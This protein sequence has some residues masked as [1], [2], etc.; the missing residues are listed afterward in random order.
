MK[1][2]RFQGVMHCADCGEE[3]PGSDGAVLISG[4]EYF[5]LS[6]GLCADCEGV[7]A[8]VVDQLDGDAR[9]L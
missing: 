3:L 1:E 5:E 2:H 4:G 7:L 6:A 8:R 9:T